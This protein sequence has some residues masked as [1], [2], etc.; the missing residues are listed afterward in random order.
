M[1]AAAQSTP[2]PAANLGALAFRPRTRGAEP[3]QPEETIMSDHEDRGPLNRTHIN[4]NEGF[5]LRYWAKDLNV[6]LEQVRSAVRKVGTAL[7]DVRQELN[8]QGL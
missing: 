6:S 3:A 1:C 7:V 5:E 8:R 2:P 4:V